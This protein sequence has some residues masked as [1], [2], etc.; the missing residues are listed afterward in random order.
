[1]TQ[2]AH[3]AGFEEHASGIL[4]REAGI[5]DTPILDN[6]SD[7]QAESRPRASNPRTSPHL[8]LPRTLPPALP[9]LTILPTP[10]SG[11]SA[12][13]DREPA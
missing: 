3:V 11:P 7:R 10:T 13:L 4:P 12:K 8:P 2:F 9:E 5:V 6:R 1:M